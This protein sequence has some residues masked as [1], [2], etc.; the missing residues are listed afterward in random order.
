MEIP[1]SRHAQLTIPK[2]DP[3]YNCRELLSRLKQVYPDEIDAPPGLEVEELRPY[4]RQ[5]LAFML[6]NEKVVDGSD[7]IGVVQ[8]PKRGSVI[9]PGLQLTEGDLKVRG[10]WLTD[11]VGM[12]KVR[13]TQSSLSLL[14]V[15]WLF[16]CP[17]RVC[18]ML[19]LA[20]VRATHGLQSGFFQTMC[21]IGLVLA[22]PCKDASTAAD[23]A[24]MKIYQNAQARCEG[25]VQ[26][27]NKSIAGAET[28]LEEYKD[29]DADVAKGHIFAIT[30]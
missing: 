30:E 23:C 2:H 25:V 17:H 22:N 10:G 20:R 13:S 21:C 26:K 16:Q 4:Q 9:E 24:E 15:S 19:F 7:L 14:F 8:A 3:R 29:E 1:E 11:E 18:L 12:G 5:S 6:H 28:L 27:A